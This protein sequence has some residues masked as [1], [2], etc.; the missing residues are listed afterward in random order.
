[1]QKEVNKQT[2]FGILVEQHTQTLVDLMNHKFS[3]HI[4]V[5]G[6][7]NT[8]NILTDKPYVDGEEC[9]YHSGLLIIANGKDLPE[10]FNNAGYILDAP[11]ELVQIPSKKGFK[12]YLA[13]QKGKDGLYLFDSYNQTAMRVGNLRNNP[14][15]PKD[16]SVRS[17]LPK[18]FKSRSA[19][20]EKDGEN[21]IGTKTRLALVMP[22]ALG[23]NN[24]DI[25]TFQ[26]KR[27][28]Y[29]LIG[30]VTHFDINGLREE[31]FFEYRGNSIV[32][33]HRAYDAHDKSKRVET[34]LSL[35][36]LSKRAGIKF[37]EH[38]YL[39]PAPILSNTKQLPVN[40]GQGPATRYVM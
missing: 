8:H 32:G 4:F 29:G 27:S 2:L 30:K 38:R 23:Q 7:Q 3:E 33:V 25:E 1:M 35:E 17:R 15:L 19:S 40:A 28:A 16:F 11:G 26:I 31:F 9:D 37:Q 5:E 14:E 20:E 36:E 34:T 22:Y 24:R 13:G 39:P 21:D 12:S 6:A 18:D 10:R